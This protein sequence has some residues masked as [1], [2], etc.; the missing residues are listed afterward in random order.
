MLR[1][2][3]FKNE[4]SSYSS[5]SINPATWVSKTAVIQLE[6]SREALY[7]IL[8]LGKNASSPLTKSPARTGCAPE[9]GTSDSTSGTGANARDGV[10]AVR[11]HLLL[12]LPW[13]YCLPLIPGSP[14]MSW[15][16]LRTRKNASESITF[17]LRF[18]RIHYDFVS[19]QLRFFELGNLWPNGFEQLKTFAMNSGY[20]CELQDLPTDYTIQLRSSRTDYVSAANQKHC[21]FVAFRDIRGLCG[22]W[23]L[24][25]LLQGKYEQIFLS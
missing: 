23:V 13:F 19:N 9:S 1:G 14:N 2:H 8:W 18:L 15:E 11:G 10:V 7:L 25:R 16:Y 6:E 24:H 20:P 4:C 21:Q 5:C 17:Q 22:I 12:S 3:Q